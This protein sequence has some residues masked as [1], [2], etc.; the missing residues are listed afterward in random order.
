MA[1]FDVLSGT[2]DPLRTTLDNP[3]SW[4]KNSF[5]G[6]GISKAGVRV[7]PD[8][9]MNSIT[10][11]SC[12]KVIAEDLAKLPLNLHFRRADGSREKARTHPVFKL[13]RRK[14]NPF[15]TAYQFKLMM[16]LHVSVRNNAYAVILE[17]E[18][19]EPTAIVPQHPDKVTV[20]KSPNGDLFYDLGEGKGIAPAENI[21]HLRGLSDDGIMG[22]NPVFQIA[23]TLGID[24]AST[25]HAA[26]YYANGARPGV[27][28]SHPKTLSP[29]AKTEIKSKWDEQYRG[30]DNT[31]SV[32]VLAEGMT[33]TVMN[34]NHVE[35]QF[36]ES[37]QFTAYQICGAMRVAPHL[38]GLMEKATF[39]N[40]EH[41]GQSHA[42]NC[43]QPHTV[44][45]TECLSD[46]LLFEDEQEDYYFEFNF[47][48]LIQ[49]DF[50]TRM[51]GYGKAIQT[52]ILSPNEA[53]EK[54][55]MNRRT[56]ADGDKYM[57]PKNM[58]LNGE[59]DEK[60]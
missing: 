53:R 8:K 33:A 59:R 1:I 44:M 20:L 39:S 32:A 29:D 48:S 47:D 34:L 43:I 35:S 9:A 51:N 50:E 12:A 25:A 22:I 60:N 24:L 18:N 30:A 49:T 31:Q 54:E 36:L 6:A 2:G 46:K 56:D 19:G 57:M 58:S 13:V 23:Q 27:V 37:R 28:L 40:I 14:P 5:G 41:Q 55:N 7:T 16:Q 42:G 3:E 52:G 45:W 11:F 17:D 4:F 38:V 10:F 21:I 15:Q 26:A